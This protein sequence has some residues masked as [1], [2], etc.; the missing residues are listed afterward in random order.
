[1][2]KN[3]KKWK[4]HLLCKRKWKLCCLLSVHKY[5]LKDMLK[6][7][8]VSVCSRNYVIFYASLFTDT[9]LYFPTAQAT[10]ALKHV[11]IHTHTGTYFHVH[12]CMCVC[13]CGCVFLQIARRM[14]RFSLAKCYSSARMS[15]KTDKVFPYGL[16][17]DDDIYV[18]RYIVHSVSVGFYV[19][20]F[21][22][23]HGAQISCQLS[24]EGRLKC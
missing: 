18:Y 13:A 19:N 4:V 17:S 24:N 10:Y 22:M 15:T 3:V 11:C 23:S 1:M 9:Q 8:G 21:K 12:T 20:H 6:C 14:V 2:T 5:L 7:V 16:L